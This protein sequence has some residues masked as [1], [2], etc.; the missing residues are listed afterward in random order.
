MTAASS[1]CQSH[2]ICWARLAMR[3]S[4]G[5]SRLPTAVAPSALPIDWKLAKSSPAQNPLPSPDRTT[6]RTDRS[7]ASASP[8]SR[9]AATMAPSR[10][11]SLSG[12]FRRTSAT[13][14][15]TLYETRSDMAV[16]ISAVVRTIH[17]TAWGRR[18]ASAGVHRAW[19]WAERIGT[20]A[21]TDAAAGRFHSIGD[22]SAI[23][24]PPGDVFGQSRIAIGS[25][26]L[27]A[28][29]VSLSVGM[30]GEYL[31]PDDDPVIT[32]GDRCLIGRGSSVIAR[33]RVEIADDVTIAPAVYV[34]DHNHSYANVQI[35]IGQQW[36]AED[37]VFIGEGSWLGS[38][39]IVLPGARI[40][41]HVTVAAGSIVR[42]EIPDYS[43]IAG[44]PAKVVR[45][46]TDGEGWVPPVRTVVVPPE[47]WPG[48]AA[49]SAG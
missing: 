23:A 46:Y 3:P 27:I 36:P 43:V 38:G 19:H 31:D 47:G 16:M 20:I 9:M 5:A 29:F 33:R 2:A 11:L 13:P 40:G 49:T 32:I 26:T 28:A 17:L 15:A 10:A 39:V 21:P 7:A 34:T 35:P 48:S 1:S 25:G 24:F 37:A 42:G 8:T 14:P 12:R 30:P 22:N 45:R 44:A 6:A 41:R 18:L 4:R